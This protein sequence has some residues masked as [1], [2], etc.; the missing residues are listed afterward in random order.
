MTT[1]FYI[2]SF[3]VVSAPQDYTG[4][5]V[6]TNSDGQSV[7]ARLI[8]SD[9]ESVKI[10]TREYRIYDILIEDLSEDD[11][12]IVVVTLGKDKFDAAL[13]YLD[14]ELNKKK[15]GR[16]VTDVDLPY[17]HDAANY[18]HARYALLESKLQPL[19][20]FADDSTHWQRLESGMAYFMTDWLARARTEDRILFPD[21]RRVP[22]LEH[23]VLRLREF[24]EY[25]T[26]KEDGEPY[27]QSRVGMLIP[28]K[29]VPE[30]GVTENQPYH[31]FA[32]LPENYGSSEDPLLFV[33]QGAGEHGLNLDNMRV[34]ELVKKLAKEKDYPILC[35]AIQTNDE[36][37]KPDYLNVVFEDVKQR[38]TFN[39]DRVVAS[40]FS[41]GGAGVWRWGVA[42]P[43]HFAAL[44]PICGNLP[45]YE[46]RRLQSMP[47]WLF[48]NGRD[49]VYIQER[50]IA[51]LEGM[52]API[53]NTIYEDGKGHNAWTAAYNEDELVQWIL[54]QRR[55]NTRDIPPP[56]FSKFAFDDHLTAPEVQ[57]IPAAEYVTLMY[58]AREKDVAKDSIMQRHQKRY[59]FFHDAVL[60][61]SFKALNQYVRH[62][63]QQ[64]AINPLTR[65]IDRDEETEYIFGIETSGLSRKEVS[66]PFE[67]DSARTFNCYTSYYLSAISDPSAALNRLRRMA[68]DEGFELTGEDRVVYHQPFFDDKQFYE[69]QVGIR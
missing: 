18:L 46:I 50:A 2:I 23:I 49:N 66:P 30:G 38:L 16:K 33:M 65:F 27:M 5:R 20:Q 56:P 4:F 63:L 67:L 34:Q 55:D 21:G 15:K 54:E 57:S 58:G 69:L 47:V 40:G 14:E 52:G 61:D 22:F 62:N 6:W 68:E 45:L 36:Y 53:K 26:A 10:E 9:E 43:E 41:A 44:V 8:N 60:N 19:G 59:G 39:E 1:F 35:A 51:T 7:T 29:F 32:Y 64:P 37:Y 28:V 31:Y 3:F 17:I 12:N 24:D 25:I 48:N 11:R 42:N 13:R